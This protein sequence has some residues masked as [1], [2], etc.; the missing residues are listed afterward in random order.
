MRA[1]AFNY[2]SLP[3]SIARVAQ[4]QSPLATSK[5]P[6]RLKHQFACGLEACSAA[7][8]CGARDAGDWQAHLVARTT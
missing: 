5:A 1:V 3:S 7:H 8:A 4:M 6:D 2:E